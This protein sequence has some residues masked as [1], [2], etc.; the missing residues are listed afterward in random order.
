MHA[1]T[2]FFR[3]VNDGFHIDNDCDND[4]YKQQ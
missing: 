1:L 3:T 2:C 4:E